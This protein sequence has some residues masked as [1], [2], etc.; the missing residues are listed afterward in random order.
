VCEVVV[1]FIGIFHTFYVLDLL[2][3]CFFFC[4]RSAIVDLEKI[5]STDSN[6]KILNN[7]NKIIFK[8]FSTTLI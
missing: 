3:S 4:Y 2:F 7:N 5:S 1:N 6:F 8:V